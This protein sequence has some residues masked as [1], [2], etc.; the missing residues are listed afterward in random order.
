MQFYR[1]GIIN[2]HVSKLYSITLGLV[3]SLARNTLVRT[4]VPVVE[5]SE[6]HLLKV[7][8]DSLFTM[9]L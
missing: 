4:S 6:S 7:Y 1:L 9:R 8:L 3:A 5:V 2:L